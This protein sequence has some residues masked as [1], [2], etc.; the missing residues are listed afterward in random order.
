MLNGRLQIAATVLMLALMSG[1]SG[2]TGNSTFGNGSG[3]GSGN[4]TGT[5]PS[6]GTPPG[7]GT[8]PQL[9][10]TDFVSGLTS[11]VGFEIAPND[12]FGRIF[13]LEQAGTIRIVQNNALLP[14]PFL[15]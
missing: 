5:P 15:N 13:V 14:A 4:G 3:T 1:C 8:P 12:T 6:S 7:S 2:A 9:T 10:L 11:P